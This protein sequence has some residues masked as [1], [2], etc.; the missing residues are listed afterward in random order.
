MSLKRY[1][2]NFLLFSVLLAAFCL[3]LARGNGTVGKTETEQSV[4]GFEENRPVI[5]IDAGHGGEDGGASAADGTVEK[6]LNLEIAKTVAQLLDCAG[7]DVRMTR[8]D[9]RMLYDLYGEA[10]QARGHKKAYDLRSRLRFAREANA[11]LLVSIHMNSFPQPECS[12]LQVYYAPS[13]KSR[14]AADTIQSYTRQFLQPQNTRVSKA[15]TSAIYL[16]HRSEMPSVLIEC[17]FLTN[18]SELRKLKD[19]EYRSALSLVI[20]CAV[21]EC[22]SAPAQEST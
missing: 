16:L 15:A 18:E 2:S 6:D 7:F 9:D 20:A 21:S 19:P 17:G 4:S 13:D 8:S 5:V 1:I 22:F 3:I 12:G 11:S 10:E 14:A